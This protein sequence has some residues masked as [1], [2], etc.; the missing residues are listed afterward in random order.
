VGEVDEISGVTGE[1]H[2]VNNSAG[3]SPEAQEIAQALMDDIGDDPIRFI[4]TSTQPADQF[5]FVGNGRSG[6]FFENHQGFI[7]KASPIECELEV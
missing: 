3:R 1:S 6:G 4:F 5:E 7:I 2:P